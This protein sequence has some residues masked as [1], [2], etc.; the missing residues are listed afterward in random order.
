MVGTTT[1]LEAFMHL[2]NGQ[3][4]SGILSM[5]KAFDDGGLIVAAICTPVIGII[6][7]YCVHLLVNVSEHVCEQLEIPIPD[8]EQLAEYTLA[9]GWS[10]VKKWSHLAKIVTSLFITLSQV[11]AC[12]VYYLF[13]AE[14]LKAFFDNL[15]ND[16]SNNNNNNTGFTMS[17][18]MYLLILLPVI[19]LLQFIKNVR[20]LAIPSTLANLLQVLGLGIIFYNIVQFDPTTI[21]TRK[22]VGSKFPLYFVTTIFNFEGISIGM[23]LYKTMANPK[24]FARPI[25]GIV[26]ITNII[27]VSLNLFLGLFGYLKY[28]SDVGASVTFSMPNEPVYN[29]VQ[30]MYGFA[31][32]M[33]YPITMYV[34][35][36]MLWPKI[37]QRF[38]ENKIST[39]TIN[40]MEYIFRAAC[41]LLTYAMAL[42]IPHLDIILSLVGALTS[43]SIQI[44]IP[45]ILHTIC[46]WPLCKSSKSRVLLFTKNLCIVAI[47]FAAFILGTYYS[48][49]DLIA[50]I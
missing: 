2:V 38:I 1:N 43:S 47:G 42:L 50:A 23:P 21:G 34:P 19:A 18:D 11:G 5:P 6:T 36:E 20:I 49:V 13:I 25:T 44:L 10:P 14:N 24:A 7:T 29:S 46:F 48:I 17:L 45:A 3:I 12:A 35:I 4:G 32:L 8:Y 22:Q 16:T 26:D 37:N 28:G 9:I 31:V 39:G 41:V 27:I 30:V 40:F 15:A 33:T